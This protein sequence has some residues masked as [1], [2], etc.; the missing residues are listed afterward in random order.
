[1]R[2]YTVPDWIG[3][4]TVETPE[5]SACSPWLGIAIGPGS[6]EGAVLVDGV[7][8]QAGRILP[9]RSSKYTISKRYAHAN[10]GAVDDMQSI[11]KLVLMLFEH[12]SELSVNVARPN[13]RFRQRTALAS[14]S[15]HVPFVGRR[16]LCV[17]I[18]WGEGSAETC[19]YQ[20]YG[21]SYSE[22]AEQ[23][24]STTLADESAVAADDG[25]GVTFYIGGT[26]EA[27]CFEEIEIAAQTSGADLPHIEAEVIGELGV[28]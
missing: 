6:D 11:A 28:P 13:A 5:A 14:N 19:S 25:G 12:P 23:V 8:L 24:T 15:L 20:V 9:L 10:G 21:R 2:L 3:R 22:A 1:M 18:Q 7:P 4:F 16:Q 17:R 27:E 26:N